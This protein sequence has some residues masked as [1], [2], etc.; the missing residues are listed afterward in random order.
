MIAEKVS[1]KF[2]AHHQTI[3]SIACGENVILTAGNDKMVC[4][5]DSRYQKVSVGE[6]RA[7]VGT[8]TCARFVDDETF[9]SCGVD[10]RVQ[11][12]DTRCLRAAVVSAGVGDTLSWID[13]DH[14]SGLVCVNCAANAVAVFSI[15]D[16]CGKSSKLEI[17][18]QCYGHVNSN[19]ATGRSYFIPSANAIASTSED[20][21]VW[22]WPIENGSNEPICSSVVHCGPSWDIA[23][24]ECRDCVFHTCGEDGSITTWELFEYELIDHTNTSKHDRRYHL[25]LLHDGLSSHT[26]SL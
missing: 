18:T 11:M 9:L 16:I 2:S 7:H 14:K 10:G 3:R 13:I 15:V 21:C 1:N 25:L 6:V 12:W 23:A 26:S 24:D 5:W 20:G 19:W 17:Q 8:A 22:V 4:L